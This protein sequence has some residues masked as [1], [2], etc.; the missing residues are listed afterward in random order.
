MNKEHLVAKS[1]ETLATDLVGDPE[2]LQLLD[3]MINNGKV[4]FLMD[5]ILP[6]A[7]DS[8]KL[9]YTAAQTQWCQDNELQIWS[10]LVGEELLYSTR[11]RDVR[12]LVD[13]SPNAPGMPAEAPGRVANWIGWQ[14]VKAYMKRNP[15]VTFEQLLSLK[16]GQ[17]I[18]DL[19]K[20][21][22]R[23]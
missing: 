22:P 15:E 16:D 13:H 8:I 10:H 18:L 7:P 21:K 1:I 3:I 4:L 9:G 12:K 20:Y 11:M 14:I 5:Q 6:Y 17:Q 19:S 2:K 23:I